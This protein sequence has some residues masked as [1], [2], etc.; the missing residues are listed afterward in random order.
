[1][2][3][4]V[5]V[6]LLMLPLITM[7]AIAEDRRSGRL[8]FYFSLPLAPWMLVVGRFVALGLA[9]IC[10]WLL[11]ALQPLTLLRGSAL[12]VG[13]YNTNLIGMGLFMMM[14]LALGV[15]CSS[16]ARNPLIAAALSASISLG[17]WFLAGIAHLQGG[18][19]AVGGLS[20]AVRLRSFAH[21]MLHPG[22]IAYFV[23]GTLALMIAACWFV[24]HERTRS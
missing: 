11:P 6:L 3:G 5:T 23:L 16:A 14:H 18:A 4:G 22:D 12:D 17:L 20:T 7:G 24:Q 13:V 10:I 19:A 9:V 21:G 1:M 8:R 15:C 2:Q